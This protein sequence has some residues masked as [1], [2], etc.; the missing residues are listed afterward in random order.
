MR[1]KASL[2]GQKL[3]CFDEKKLLIKYTK[4]KLMVFNKK[5]NF[6]K[7][8]KKSPRLSKIKLLKLT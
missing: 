2:S 1:Q 4:I 5:P 6:K 8:V 3:A 7:K